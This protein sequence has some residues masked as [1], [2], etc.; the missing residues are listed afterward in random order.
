MISLQAILFVFSEMNVF[1]CDDSEIIKRSM[2]TQKYRK[3]VLERTFFLT[4]PGQE[5]KIRPYVQWRIYQRVADGGI[6][7]PGR[8]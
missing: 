3:N 2:I 5:V 6:K 4:T 7:L 1:L 8:P